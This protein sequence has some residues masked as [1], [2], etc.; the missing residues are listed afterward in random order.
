MAKNERVTILVDGSNMYHYMKDLSLTALLE[1]NYK[2]FGEFLARGRK[3]QSA[4]YYIG[5]MREKPKDLRSRQLMANQQKLV[6][7]LQ[8]YGWRISYGHMLIDGGGQREKGVD[9][10]IAVDLVVGAYENIY[11]AALLVSSD[12]DLIP[13][14]KTVKKKGKKLEYIGFS[15]S[16]SYGLIKNSTLTKTLAKEDL[17]QFLPH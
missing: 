6:S 14:I 15:R 11:D 16:P 2:Q 17:E 3:I 10:Q 12:T 4:T 8:N 9:V 5:K 13:A 1:F 7:L